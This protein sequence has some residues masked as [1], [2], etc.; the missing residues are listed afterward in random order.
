LA[1]LSSAAG[2]YS[3]YATK[4]LNF[5]Y[6]AATMALAFPYTFIL[7]TPLYTSL[8]KSDE[9]NQAS[10]RTTTTINSWVKSHTGRLLIGVV[11]GLLYLLAE[12]TSESKK[13]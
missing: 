11:T 1:A 5:A 3:Y 6:G 2:F 10:D 7:L 8:L 12:Y 4:N 9:E 13:I